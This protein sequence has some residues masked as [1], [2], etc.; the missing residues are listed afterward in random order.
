M[1]A[2]AHTLHLVEYLAQGGIERLLEQ[3]ARYT[4][5]SRTKLIFFSY[6][7]QTVEGI[8]KELVELGVPV[9]TYKKRGGYDPGLLLKLIRLVQEQKITVV[10]THD[11]GPMEYA[12]ALKLRFPRLRLIH[13]HHTL[14]HFLNNRKYLFFFQ[15]GSHFY[16]RV[17]AVSEH[18]KHQI[19]KHCPLAARNIVVIPNGVALDQ[20]HTG[21][22]KDDGRL[23]LVNISRLSPEKNLA[24]V[25][26]TCV[27]LKEANIPFE[28]HHAG[29]GSKELEAQT[30]A[31]IAEHGLTDFVHLYGFQTDVR[32]I[33]SK[34]NIFVSSS[35]TE[36]HPVAVLEA[37]ASGKAC[38]ISDIP[39]HR[40]IAPGAVKLFSIQDETALFRLLAE[41]ALDSEPV[42]A[43]SREGRKQVRLRYGIDRM[44]ESYC[45]LYA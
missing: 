44:I 8:G 36:G 39:P 41:A 22:S 16:F 2:R 34:G 45:E 11:F 25:L 21:R 6:E 27:R 17:I 12:V 35:I 7:T 23:K 37:M 26:R 42:K 1:T 40:T 20:F 30:R 14:V 33:L 3:I 28:L 19:V 29:S 5:A 15:V 9:F 38:M 32:K 10:H 4:P 24:Y 13:T 18:V 43:L 31:F